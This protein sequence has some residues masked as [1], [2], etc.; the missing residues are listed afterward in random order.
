M[1]YAI[2]AVGSG[3]VKFGVTAFSDTDERLN[4]MQTGCPFELVV[5]A[6]AM[7]PDREEFRIHRHLAAFRHRGEWFKIC[8]ETQQVIAVMDEGNIEL[9][10]RLLGSDAPS[11]LRRILKIVLPQ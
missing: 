7:W 4:A 3:F 9:W 1:I 11:R 8:Q 10:F 5:R 2:E 6:T